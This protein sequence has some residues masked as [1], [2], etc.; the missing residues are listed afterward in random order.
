MDSWGQHPVS[1]PF[2]AES[3]TEVQTI[4]SSV[5][6]PAE[7]SLIETLG[8]MPIKVSEAAGSETTKDII[9]ESGDAT[10]NTI[11][12]SADIAPRT[13][14][15]CASASVLQPVETE[16][17]DAEVSVGVIRS[18]YGEL[19]FSFFSFLFFSS[20][21]WQACCLGLLLWCYSSHG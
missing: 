7:D 19:C 11:S 6:Q 12:C 8:H 15:C 16:K 20:M 21:N 13:S 4:P 14:T 9:P 18:C 2:D 1:K 17:P 5:Y 10:R 3:L